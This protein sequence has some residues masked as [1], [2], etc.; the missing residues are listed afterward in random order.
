MGLRPSALTR[1]EAHQ[2]ISRE[3]RSPT[4]TVRCVARVKRSKR[5]E[6]GS[7]GFGARR[8]LAALLA[9]NMYN[10]GMHRSD[11]NEIASADGPE[12]VPPPLLV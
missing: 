7:A 8:G 6:G 9:R 1:W 2:V 4:E 11:R 12:K 10:N 5:E 3:Q